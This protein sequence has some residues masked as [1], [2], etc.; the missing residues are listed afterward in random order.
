MINF[1]VNVRRIF[2]GNDFF[3]YLFIYFEVGPCVVKEKT[4]F[5]TI[6]LINIFKGLFLSTKNKKFILEKEKHLLMVYDLR[7]VYVY[8]YVY[9]QLNIV[10]EYV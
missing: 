9:V 4:I 1:S 2:Y 3:G 10:K 8:C 7:Y 5:F 6:I